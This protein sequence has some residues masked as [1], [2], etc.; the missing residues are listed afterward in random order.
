M[1]IRLFGFLGLHHNSTTEPASAHARTP[2]LDDWMGERIAG[3]IGERA[4]RR[5][6]DCSPGASDLRRAA[7]RMGAPAWLA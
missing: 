5:Y 4:T 1:K 2:A 3:D 7:A 6:D